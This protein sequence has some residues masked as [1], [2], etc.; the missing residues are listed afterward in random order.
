MPTINLKMSEV[1]CRKPG[2]K[3]R[4]EKTARHHRGC[5]TMFIRGF[6]KHPDV[7]KKQ[8]YHKL[9][10]RYERFEPKD[11]IV[12]CDWHH[13]EIHL[14]YDPIIAERR[15]ELQK[16]LGEFTWAE[17]DK[18]MGQLRKL[19]REWEKKETP[20]RDPKDCMPHRRFPNFKP[21]RRR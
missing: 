5:E 3:H 16:I 9:C 13:C 15:V 18:L 19:C 17:A 1:G 12:L 10:K 14:I 2:C 8:R 4:L 11:V 7:R 21:K 6:A 20:G